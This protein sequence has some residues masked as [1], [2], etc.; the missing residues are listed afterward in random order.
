VPL[1][2]YGANTR[3]AVCGATLPVEIQL[4]AAAA[5]SAVLF[6]CRRPLTANARRPSVRRV[7]LWVKSSTSP[8]IWLCSDGQRGAPD[9]QREFVQDGWI[10]V[11][12]AQ[13][14]PPTQKQ[15]KQKPTL[16]SRSDDARVPTASRWPTNEFVPVVVRSTSRGTPTARL[17]HQGTI[18]APNGTQPI[19]SFSHTHRRRA[20]LRRSRSPSPVDMPRG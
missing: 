16:C 13:A 17:A 11:E 6:M 15:L 12:R 7:T 2:R 9:V 3:H 20:P 8:S 5:G 19:W 4:G 14:R 1:T 10:R 18:S